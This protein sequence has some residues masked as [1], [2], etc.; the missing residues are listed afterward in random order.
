MDIS[1]YSAHILVNGRK[2]KEYRH[3]GLTFVEAKDGTEFAIEVKNH[4]SGRVLAIVSVDGL[5]IVDGKVATAKSRGYIVS[6]NN[7]DTFNGWRKSKE[8]V[9]NFKFTTG[10]NSYST[11]KGKGASNGIIGIKLI[12]EKFTPPI[13]HWQLAAQIEPDD[14]Y[15][16]FPK[17]FPNYPKP[18]WGPTLSDGGTGVLG[19]N[20]YFR[21]A[22]GGTS[23]R[24]HNGSPTSDVVSSAMY[25]AVS[26]QEEAP[27]KFDMGTTWGALRNDRVQE[28]EFEYG[29]E[30]GNFEFYYASR[31]AL[32]A[33]GVPLI[34]VREVP[35][36]PKAFEGEGFAQP[37][38]NWRP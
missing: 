23:M 21:C 9:S 31:E 12:A 34:N 6:G 22:S 10:K 24:A 20:D 11:E 28:T 8:Q 13:L 29:N 33:M 25:C 27:A 5:D 32:Q 30:I 18:Y 3:N 36:L 14:Y 35:A 1:G 17:K 4:R 7:A 16:S 38:K 15:N 37:P 26:S 2:V 19:H